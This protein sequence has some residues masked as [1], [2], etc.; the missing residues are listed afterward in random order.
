MQYK[1]FK[2]LFS[3]L[4]ETGLYVIE[5]VYHFEPSWYEKAP[6]N[7]RWSRHADTSG[8]ELVFLYPPKSKA[9]L[10]NVGLNNCSAG[11]K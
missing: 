4:T 1:T 9:S 10:L 11:L 8:E 7:M 3:S 2:L 5:D 6:Y